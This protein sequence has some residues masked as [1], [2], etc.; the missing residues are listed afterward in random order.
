MKDAKLLA[1]RTGCAI[2]LAKV[3]LNRVGG[4]ADAL[5]AA[6]CLLE[7]GPTEAYS[8]D[9]CGDAVFRH[10][11]VQ[12]LLDVARDR[13]RQALASQ[14]VA[15]QWLICVR[16]Y[17]RAGVSP[18]QCELERLL[19]GCWTRAGLNSLRNSLNKLGINDVAALK[20]ELQDPAA[21]RQRL[22]NEGLYAP[23]PSSLEQLRKDVNKKQPSLG[24]CPKADRGIH[25]FTLQALERA[26]GPEAY[27]RCLIFVSHEDKDFLSGKYMRTLKQTP[28]A[29]RIVQGI[30]GAHMQVR[31]IEEAS[32]YGAHVLIADDNI[33]DFVVECVSQKLIDARKKQGEHDEMMRPLDY[34]FREDPLGDAGLMVV[35][36][37]EMQRFLRGAFSE[38]MNKSRCRAEVKEMLNVCSRAKIKT[39][40]KL[41]ALLDNQDTPKQCQLNA[42]LVS[43]G[44]KAIATP[45]IRKMLAQKKQPLPVRKLL[46][47]KHRRSG[48]QKPISKKKPLSKKNSATPELAELISRAAYEMQ[49]QG[50]N[51]WSVSPTKNHYFLHGF[52]KQMRIK[53]RKE[54][55]LQEFNT[56]LGLVYGAFFGFRALHDP[57]RY[58]RFGQVKDDVERTLRYWHH[59]RMILRFARYGIF[60]DNAK[61]VGK[62]HANKGGISTAS[63][64]EAHTAEGK[65]ALTGIL[66]EFA[67]PYAR[68]AKPGEQSSTGLV[69]R[70]D[71]KETQESKKRSHLK[72]F[73][74]PDSAPGDEKALASPDSAS[75]DEK[76]LVSPD[77]APSDEKALAAPDS[78]SGDV[79]A[80]VSPDWASGD[81]KRQRLGGA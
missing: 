59:D 65:R 53:A 1:E 55:V 57:R 48:C 13:V 31:F 5:D 28:W 72:A 3:V 22:L 4:S 32:P 49:V 58:S 54:G 16:T 76:A 74:S 69:W 10:E 77:S 71:D 41:L 52:G 33:Q 36:E 23:Q 46:V 70:T 15:D 35:E 37:S 38:H 18:Q 26:L 24:K 40:P 11:Y 27:K 79:K 62:F 67:S 66:D 6:A 9:A 42:H 50:A 30:K 29:D 51:I 21:L 7:R 81:E 78:A 14:P 75:G 56:K 2:D 20:S 44:L 60:K 45:N 39:L 68:L 19:H 80:L 47:E 64:A 34:R 63:S 73:A 61:L 43:A 12:C 25:Q 17:G 8:G